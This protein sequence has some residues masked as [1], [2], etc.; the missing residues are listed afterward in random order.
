MRIVVTGAKGAGKSTV[1]ALLAEK[2][3]L[4][5]VET[6]HLIEEI[7]E[8]ITEERLTFR[9][10]HKKHGEDEF[11]LLER[12]A[13]KRLSQRDWFV[14]ITGGSTLLN[15]DS[16]RLIRE[17]SIVVFLKA[18]PEALECR[19][20]KAGPLRGW[21]AR[22]GI[23][24]FDEYATLRNE[25]LWPF[26]DIVLDT[27]E[28]TPEEIANAAVEA[29]QV[30][31]AIRSEA[32]NT[33]GDLIRMTTFGESHGKAVGAV[34]DGLKPGI[35]VTEED[36]Q[37]ELDRRRPGQSAVT[38]QRSESDTVHILSGVYE[39]KT[40][41]H[42]IALV[43]YNKDQD[44]SRY[45][46]I[47]DLFRPGHAD[48]TFYKKYGLRDHRGGGRSSA[49]ETAARVACGAIAKKMLA[50]RG[51]KIIAHTV[52]I[53]G[54]Q[55]EKVDYGT[56]E[57]NAVRCAD[58]D[59]ADKMEAA[60]LEAKRDHDSVGGIV[61]LEIEGIPAGLG[62]PV[63]DKIKADLGKALFSLPA[64]LG[65]EY[66]IGFGCA[67]LRGSQNN[68]VFET[69]RETNRGDHD[70][71]GDKGSRDRS[72]F[73]TGPHARQRGQRSDKGW[74]LSFQ[75]CRRATRRDFDWPASCHARRDQTDLLDR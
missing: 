13:V 67:E 1:G 56:I 64:V 18:L 53:A 37:K 44:S 26:S 55:S 20:K 27:S 17:N 63:F 2:L 51:V 38:T 14:L 61:Q 42:P 31:I 54:V 28:G 32:P 3:G 22:G 47:K 43:I 11:R 33:C 8:E 66:G 45:E 35:E 40:T 30:E 46:S 34:L 60:I 41:G 75:Q 19:A 57:F 25:S 71:P 5:A 73:R 62:D 68:D 4:V 48:F 72:R 59:A 23:E 6:D 39:G 15:P 49:R 10:V 50:E 12:E 36:I 9:E 65:V 69:R 24:R 52:E 70:D 74:R 21:L 58:P 7:N 16:R 29:I